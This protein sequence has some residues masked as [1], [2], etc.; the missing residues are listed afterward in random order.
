[1]LCLSY[2]Y[3]C[4]LFNK[5]GEQDG[6]KRFCLEVNEKVIKKERKK[7]RKRSLNSSALN[8]TWYSIPLFPRLTEFIFFSCFC[9]SSNYKQLQDSTY[10]TYLSRD[11]R[12]FP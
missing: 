5:I 11:K 10:L 8:N 4:F 9:L 6:G 1:M 7:E 2:Y 3:I 12:I